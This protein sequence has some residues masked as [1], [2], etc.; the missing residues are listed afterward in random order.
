MARSIPTS[1]TG[2]ALEPCQHLVEV[3]DGHLRVALHGEGPPVL[4]LHGWTLDARMWRPQ[5]PLAARHRLIIPDR[6]GCGGSSAPPALDRE[7]EDV[8]RLL[9]HLG[10]DRAALVGL[11]QGAAVALDAARRHPGRFTHLALFGAPLP[12][13]VPGAES[14]HLPRAHYA[15]LVR[16]GR[17]EEMKAHWRAHPLTQASPAT[18]MLFDEMLADYEGRDQL[19]D[20]PPFAFAPRD[21]TGLSM[22]LL[23]GTGEGDSAWRRAGVDYLVRMAPRAREILFAKAGHLC[24]CDAP[25]AFNAALASFLAIES[26]ASLG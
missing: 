13:L 17:L 1:K 4:F 11:S 16:A 8:I 20:M 6:R 25:D 3:G 19:V 26:D 7:H 9:D 21:V 15:E 23:A 22:P 10:I 2:P 24:N 14:E 12:G 5:L 18:M